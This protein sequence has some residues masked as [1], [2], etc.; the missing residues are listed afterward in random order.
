MCEFIHIMHLQP[1]QLS[2][3]GNATA[4][5]GKRPPGARGQ[6]HRR[7]RRVRGRVGLGVDPPVDNQ[8]HQCPACTSSSFVE[9]ALDVVLLPIRSRLSLC[10]S[11]CSSQGSKLWC[12]ITQSFSVHGQ[13]LSCLPCLT[14]V[15]REPFDQRRARPVWQSTG[16]P[17]GGHQDKCLDNCSS[18]WLVTAAEN[19]QR[20]TIHLLTF[21]T[22]FQPNLGSLPL[23]S[24]L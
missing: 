21:H 19:G 20:F 8:F 14:G 15:E 4:L 22:A 13:F 24:H 23:P 7:R 17:R 18:R 3:H 5:G 12:S 11:F 9:I 10:D 16:A 1:P 6:M 2:S